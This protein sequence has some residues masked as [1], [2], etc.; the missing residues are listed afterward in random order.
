MAKQ[1]AL[2]TLLELAQMRTDDAAKRL[3]ALNAQGVD[4]EAKLALLVQYWQEYSSRFQASMKQG[5]TASDW[6]NYQEFLDKLDAAIVQQRG[7]LAAARQRVD[8]GRLDWQSARRTLK[9]YHTLV[10]RQIRTELLHLTRREQKETD[11]Y[12]VN[13]AARPKE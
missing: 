13:A 1:S 6:R 10:Q 12:V 2:D 7:L 11:E 4:M 8:D 3:G 9:S 5:I